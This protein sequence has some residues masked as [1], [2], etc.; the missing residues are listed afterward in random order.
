[1][2]NTPHKTVIVLAQVEVWAF[3]PKKEKLEREEK[4]VYCKTPNRHHFFMSF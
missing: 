4:N 1:M 2:E 3:I